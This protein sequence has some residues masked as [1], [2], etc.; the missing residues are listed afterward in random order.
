MPRPRTPPGK[1]RSG[2][3][4]D[5][6]EDQGEKQNEERNGSLD[7]E[8]Q[9]KSEDISDSYCREVQI[10]VEEINHCLK[11][12]L[13]NAEFHD[14]A[15]LT[16]PKKDKKSTIFVPVNNYS[17]DEKEIH[18]LQAFLRQVIF[19]RFPPLELPSSWLLF[20][21]VLRHRYENS[22]GVCKLADCQA[23]AKGC[24]LDKDDILPVLR[25]L[26]QHLGTILFYEEVEGLSELVICD[27]NVLF[28]S[29]YQLVAVSFG[30]D[31]GY[32]TITDEI[33]KTGEI[34]CEV[35]EDF[36]TEPS[37][38]LLT[39]ELIINLLKHYKILKELRS[40]YGITYFMP[41]LLQP[42]NTLDLSCKALRKI[43]PPPLLFGFDGKCIPV[44]MFSALV[45][46]LSW[47][48]ARDSRY[49]NHILFDTDDVF[50]VELIVHPAYLEFRIR[51]INHNEEQEEIHK[52]CSKV[53]NTVVDTLKSILDLH[54]HTRKI[55][56]Q[57]GFY[58]P[59]SFQ[60][61]A[62]PHF[63]GC[64]PCQNHTNPKSFVCSKSPRCQDQCRLP[65]ECTVWLEYW[66]VCC[67]LVGVYLALLP[68]CACTEINH[69]VMREADKKW[70]F[71]VL[72]IQ[73]II[74]CKIAE[75]RQRYLGLA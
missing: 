30:G 18:N 25:Y 53:R 40:D 14:R 44:G 69:V 10:K 8:G 35:L 21:L 2:T 38:S 6:L 9:K 16:Y 65:H 58:C 72:L 74:P 13:S 66:K 45:V 57:L 33:R 51:V 50:P 17:G 70:R 32:L 52:F 56:F 39:N 23:L 49:C 36:S 20:H 4:L 68:R 54:E 43:Y 47:K 29:I 1:K 12:F 15:F 5:Q 61:D 19:D 7:T 67:T 64:L 28:K 60:T 59:G 55:K 11:E 34:P 26:H 27:P 62:Q 73:C 22:P 48:P 46:K 41:C 75:F 42:D 37:N 63:S 71:G 3:H 24:G 31:K